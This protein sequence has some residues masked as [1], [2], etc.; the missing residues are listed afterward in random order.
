MQATLPPRSKSRSNPD[1]P[2]KPS[3]PERFESEIRA[4]EDA[5]RRG[6]VPPGGIVFTGSSSIKNWKSLADDFPGFGCVN[7]GF[8]GSTLPEATHFA[9]R[10]LAPLRPRQVVLYS[11]DNDIA[12]GRT[13]RELLLDFLAFVEQVRRLA[14]RVPITFLAVKPSPSRIDRWP[15]A[16]SAN[17]RIANCCRLRDGLT[18][19]DVATPM[20]RA[21][22][23]PRPELYLS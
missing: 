15:V 8:G 2:P 3:G 14:P 11:G 19:V 7:R 9:T 18:F 5:Q 23:T 16:R 10:I 6:P 21:D 12:G 22:G 20:L 13:D 4:F 17:Q 1:A